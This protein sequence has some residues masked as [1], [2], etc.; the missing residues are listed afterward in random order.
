MAGLGTKMAVRTRV[1]LYG[2]A[3]KMSGSA[4]GRCDNLTASGSAGY[5]DPKSFSIQYGVPS[6]WIPVQGGNDNLTATN[7]GEYSHSNF[8]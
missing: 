2:H 8:V 5:Y 6:T 3:H 7:Q 1:A 4:Q